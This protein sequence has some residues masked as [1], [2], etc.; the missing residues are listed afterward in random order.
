MREG[1]GFYF[2][3]FFKVACFRMLELKEKMTRKE[4][5][6]NTAVQDFRIKIETI[7]EEIIEEREKR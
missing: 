5:E 2:V 4:A 7:N 3:Y 6:A 1:G